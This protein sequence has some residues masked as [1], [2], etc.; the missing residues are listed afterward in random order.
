VVNANAA[1]RGDVLA[2][3]ERRTIVRALSRVGGNLSAAARLVGISRS[4]LYRKLAAY[5]IG[6]QMV[7]AKPR[8]SA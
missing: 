8:P 7:A 4:T 3:A 5:E 2:D 1:Q 6:A